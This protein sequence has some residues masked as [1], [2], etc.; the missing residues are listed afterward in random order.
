VQKP[1]KESVTAVQKV[2]MSG[3]KEPASISGRA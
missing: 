3:G 1:I 2:V